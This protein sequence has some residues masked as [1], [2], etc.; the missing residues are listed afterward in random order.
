MIGNESQHWIEQLYHTIRRTYPSMYLEAYEAPI[1]RVNWRNIN[2]NVDQIIPSN[3]L[4][5]NT[6]IPLDWAWITAADSI[7]Y[8]LDDHDS[9]CKFLWETINMHSPLKHTFTAYKC[10][11]INIWRPDLVFVPIKEQVMHSDV[12]YYDSVK[13]LVTSMDVMCTII[14]NFPSV[15]LKWNISKTSR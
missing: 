1:T 7:Y 9:I 10:P 6:Y 2:S 3:P 8:W 5:I 13:R 15:A 11:Y 12:S 4:L 14:V